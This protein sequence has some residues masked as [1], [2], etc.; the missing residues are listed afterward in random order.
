MTTTA[1]MISTAT[2]TPTAMPTII[3]LSPPPPD[4]DVVKQLREHCMPRRGKTNT[5]SM[6]DLLTVG[7]KLT[8]TA[9]RA[10][11]A[12]IDRYLPPAP[13]LSSKPAGRRCC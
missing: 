6:L 5:T 8:R 7:P 10:A 2:V 4:A 3:P 12:T 11:A 13:D 1:T 9:C